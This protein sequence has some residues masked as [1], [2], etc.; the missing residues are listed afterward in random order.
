MYIVGGG[1]LLAGLE[2]RVTHETGI[3]TFIA[4]EPLLTV[5][6]GAG[7]SLENLSTIK[8]LAP[9]GDD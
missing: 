1:A 2:E 3:Q 5:I 7:L 6:L 9:Q 4:S 8:G